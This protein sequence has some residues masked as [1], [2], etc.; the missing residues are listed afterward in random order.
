LTLVFCAC[1]RRLIVRSAWALA[2]VV[3]LGCAAC[4]T[5]ASVRGL[6]VD[7]AALRAELEAFRVADARASRDLARLSADLATTNS[8]LTTLAGDVTDAAATLDRLA[9]RVGEA[10]AQVG[11]LQQALTDLQSAAG[12][13]SPAPAV[14]PERPDGSAASGRP[15]ADPV[16]QTY[17]AALRAF[18]AGEHGQAVLEFLGFLGRF[19]DHRLASN[20]QYWIGEAYY[21]Q[22]DYRQAI[23]E[24][25]KVLEPDRPGGKVPDALVKLGLCYA[26]LRQPERARR[27]WRQVLREHPRAEAARTARA[28]LSGHGGTP[29]RPR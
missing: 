3:T 11:R 16:E 2:L 8:R 23:T 28:L 20:A 12:P 22:R 19:P 18:R 1:Y 29:R 24:F 21:A 10:E 9:A 27:Y 15:G 6:R 14:A 25:R 4:A 26:R 5:R 17:A 13:R 7:I